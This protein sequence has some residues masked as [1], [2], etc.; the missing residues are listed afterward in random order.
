MLNRGSLETEVAVNVVCVHA[1]AGEVFVGWQGK[2]TGGAMVSEGEGL[3]IVIG[4]ISY[5]FNGFVGF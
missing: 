5:E 3:L 2:G 1:A 4:I